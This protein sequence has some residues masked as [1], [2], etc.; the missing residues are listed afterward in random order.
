MLLSALGGAVRA[1][2][3]R[4]G[5]T[6]RA[7]AQKARV[8]ERFLV[9]L[10][11]GQGNIS[12]ARLA[13]VAEALGT[14]A[15]E[16]LAADVRRT[17]P[18]AERRVIA[19][20]GL[21]GAGKTS[22]GEMVAKRL[23]VP[24]VELDALVAQE[25]GMSIPVIF[26]MHGEA[27]FRKLERRTLRKF[28]DS[29]PAAVLATGGSIVTDAETFSLLRRRALTVWLRAQPRDH[30]TRV[31]AQGDLRPMK[32]RTDA[33]AE[34]SSLLK[35]R[36]SLYAQ[37]DRIVDTS[38]VSLAEAARRVLEAAAQGRLNDVPE[39]SGQP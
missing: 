5:L 13:D 30:W 38:G 22:L 2:R 14:T 24:F 15:A 20:L 4:A 27:Y 23:K 7:L 34:L 37:A 35:A 31:V 39:S 29:T 28:L 17:S 12:V 18:R 36:K 21:R 16:L 33:M 25:A 26:E 3:A 9:Q 19:L 10:E 1:R 6:L 8:S 11:T 32:G